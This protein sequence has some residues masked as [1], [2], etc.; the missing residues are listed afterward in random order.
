MKKVEEALE[1]QKSK[2]VKIVYLVGEPGVG[3][4][5]LARK[6]GIGYA[7]KYSTSTK[8]VLTL[9]MNNFRANYSKLAVKLG[10]NH[11]ITDGQSLDTVAE[12]MK[13]IL[14]KRNYW[15]LIIDNY[16]STEYEGFESGTV[17]EAR[18]HET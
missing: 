15:L 12:E 1:K 16:N 7:A 5:Q 11:S 9:D 8:T 10:L 18:V 6:Y 2:V 4:S 3:K 17:T 13:K 14:S